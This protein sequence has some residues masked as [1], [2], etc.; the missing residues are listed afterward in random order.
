MNRLRMGTDSAN[1]DPSPVRPFRS[2]LSAWARGTLLACALATA[3]VSARAQS[4]PDPPPN[5]VQ[6]SPSIYTSGQPGPKSLAGLKAQGIEAVVYLAPPTVSDA[7]R[8]EAHIVGSQ[9]IVFVNIPIVFSD[10]TARDFETFSA[11][12]KALGTRKILVHCQVNLRAS[13]M[14][15][16]YRTVEGRENPDAAWQDVERIWIPRDPWKGF[17]AGVLARHGVKFELP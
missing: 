3:A 11:V 16:L 14:T 8:D 7:V 6:V 12:M 5:L 4:W 17:I 10:P 1:R 2:G 15:F 13:A 9:G